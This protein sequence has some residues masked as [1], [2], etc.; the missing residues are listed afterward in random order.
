MESIGLKA[1][2]SCLLCIN[3][4][5]VHANLSLLDVFI[6]FGGNPGHVCIS[7]GGN[8][9]DWHIFSLFRDFVRDFHFPDVVFVHRRR[10]RPGIDT[11]HS[12]LKVTSM[13]FDL[14][15]WKSRD[16]ISGDPASSGS[17]SQAAKEGTK[18]TKQLK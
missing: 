13:K 12:S 10:E 9:C 3:G 5:I 8:F 11:K 2:A 14:L 6:I 18:H 15:E 7:R 1:H 4:K 17:T 16:K